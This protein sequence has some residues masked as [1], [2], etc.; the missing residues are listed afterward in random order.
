M[1]DGVPRIDPDAKGREWWFLGDRRIA[2]PGLTA[3]AGVG[4][5]TK[6]PT[7]YDAMSPGAF[8]A[9]ERLAYMDAMGIR[10]MVMSPNEWRGRS[11][12]RYGAISEGRPD[13]GAAAASAGDESQCGRVRQA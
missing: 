13:L 6:W 1:K 9:K 4:D 8:D 7:S 3:T 10:T 11:A 12:G 2:N 5:M